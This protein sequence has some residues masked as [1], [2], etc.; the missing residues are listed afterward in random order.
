[1][2]ENLCFK[3]S[4]TQEELQAGVDELCEK[5]IIKG[6]F[7]TDVLLALMDLLTQGDIKAYTEN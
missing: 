1:M 6:C 4:I 7:K 3:W 5:G 2:Q